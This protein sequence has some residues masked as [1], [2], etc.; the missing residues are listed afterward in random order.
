MN[1]VGGF[2]TDPIILGLYRRAL[3]AESECRRLERTLAEV[4]A[5][6]DPSRSSADEALQRIEAA[7]ALLRKAMGHELTDEEQALVDSALRRAA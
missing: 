5:E 1:G 7:Q 2:T 4:V 6:K 3:A